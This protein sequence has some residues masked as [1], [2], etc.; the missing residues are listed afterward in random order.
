MKERSA[1]GWL[2]FFFLEGPFRPQ[3]WPFKRLSDAFLST[4]C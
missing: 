2:R 4:L 3:K 1:A